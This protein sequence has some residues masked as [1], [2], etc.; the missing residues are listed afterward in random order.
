MAPVV[1]HRVQGLVAIDLVWHDIGAVLDRGRAED[2]QSIPRLRWQYV[3]S[4]NIAG[5]GARLIHERN[6]AMVRVCAS[7][8][9]FEIV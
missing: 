4:D 5:K 1:I 8:H 3:N 9:R 6:V 7:M 2:I